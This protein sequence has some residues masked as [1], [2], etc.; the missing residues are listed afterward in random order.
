MEQVQLPAL[1]QVRS[2]HSVP[3]QLCPARQVGAGFGMGVLLR[4]QMCRKCYNTGKILCNHRFL[5]HILD[6]KY[7]QSSSPSRHSCPHGCATPFWRF[8]TN[9]VSVP[10]ACRAAPGRVKS[11]TLIDFSEL[12]AVAQTPPAP[13][14]DTPSASRHSSTAST[15]LLEDEL[16]S[17]GL[18]VPLGVTLG[19]GVWGGLTKRGELLLQCQSQEKVEPSRCKFSGMQCL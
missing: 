2:T 18:W 3:W 17:L 12:E 7:S 14:A 13:S 4:E 1:H 10:P 6:R 16:Q 8:L 5:L 15:C 9:S 19:T 11:Y